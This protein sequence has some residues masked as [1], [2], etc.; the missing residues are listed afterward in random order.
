MLKSTCSHRRRSVAGR[1]T[2]RCR[3]RPLR[4]RRR[5]RRRSSWCSSTW[6][7]RLCRPRRRAPDQQAAAA[8][9]SGGARITATGHTDT[10]GSPEFNMALRSVAPTPSKASLVTN[11]VPADAVATVRRGRSACS[12]RRATALPSRRTAASRLCSGSAA[13]SPNDAAYCKALSDQWRKFSSAQSEGHAA[14]AMNQCVKGNYAA[15]IPV[16]EKALTAT[17]SRC[18]RAWRSQHTS[19]KRRPSWPPFLSA[20]VDRFELRIDQPQRRIGLGE[21][22]HYLG[23]GIAGAALMFGSS[24]RRDWCRA[25]APRTRDRLFP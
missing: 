12:S 11:G 1:A 24:G 10:V 17:R 9:K 15:G 8:F 19:R 5:R 4:R 7:A 25:A 22:R 14:E 21:R 23:H 18:R 6:A 2:R 20:D 16:L 13:G 3:K